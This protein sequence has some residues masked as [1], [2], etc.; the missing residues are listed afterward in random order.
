[1]KLWKVGDMTVEILLL[2]LP[3]R[4]R[5]NRICQDEQVEVV[6]VVVDPCRRLLQA[7]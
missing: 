5:Y 3:R 4:K 6:V 7:A 2:L 1:M